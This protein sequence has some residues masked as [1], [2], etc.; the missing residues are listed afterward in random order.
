MRAFL[1]KTNKEWLDDFVYI[2]SIGLY[3][4]NGE[5]LA[6]AKLSKPILKKRGEVKLFK[7]NLSI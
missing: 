5:L 1:E 7:I 2:S 6:V 4:D 3:N